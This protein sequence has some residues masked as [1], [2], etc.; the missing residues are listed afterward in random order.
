M[1]NYVKLYRQKHFM[2]T[3]KLF[4]TSPKLH[5]FLASLCLCTLLISSGITFSKMTTRHP[6]ALCL[7]ANFKAPFY[8]ITVTKHVERVMATLLCFSV[9]FDET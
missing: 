8:Y 9:V 6:A 7:Q 4:F 1:Q 5:S 3:L 2:M